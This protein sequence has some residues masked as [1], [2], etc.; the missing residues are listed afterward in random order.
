MELEI[1]DYSQ[2]FPGIENNVAD[3]LSRNFHLSDENLT[4][5]L[6]SAYP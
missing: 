5:Y 6:C 1:Q 2:W 3:S 4:A